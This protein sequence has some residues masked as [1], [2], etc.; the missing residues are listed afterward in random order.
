MR[1]QIR[2]NEQQVALIQML[3]A[4]DERVARQTSMLKFAKA[5]IVLTLN[6][7]GQVKRTKLSIKAFAIGQN[8]IET[9]LKSNDIEVIHRLYTDEI[10]GTE[11]IWAVNADPEFLKQL[12]ITIDD[13]HPLGLIFDIDVLN[14]EG[15][16]VS[17]SE[18][19]K[20]VR[21]CFVCELPVS[22]CA[23]SRRHS[24]AELRAAVDSILKNFFLC[25]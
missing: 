7:P 6:M 10:T 8:E 15:K 12:M 19:G 25:N 14:N 16:K 4:R 23:S 13:G 22:H 17:R 18:V 9:L 3:N 20:G 21:K 24:V 5:I 2:Y 1:V 11:C